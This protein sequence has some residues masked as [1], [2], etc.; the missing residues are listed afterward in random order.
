MIVG[1]YRADL[2]VNESVVVELKVS[3]TY[4]TADESQLLNELKATGLRLGLLVNF[5]RERAE[6]KRMVL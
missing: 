2:L 1:Q 4:Q 3:K 6:F 5:G